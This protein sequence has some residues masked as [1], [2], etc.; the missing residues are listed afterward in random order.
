MITQ[1][2]ME[3]LQWTKRLN[4]DKVESL[5]LKHFGLQYKRY[6]ELWN[7]AG[8]DFL[9]DFPVNLDIEVVDACNLSCL[10]CTRNDDIH[11][12]MGLT[13]NTGLKF[14]L[15]SYKRICKEGR[16]YGLKAVNLGFSGECLLNNDIY[17]MINIAREYG[18]LDIRLITN[19]TLITE[20]IADTLLGTPL[21]LLSYSID[22]GNPET[23]INLKGKNYFDKLLD[24][25][26]YTYRRKTERKKDFPLI[27]VSY[28]PSPETMGD[29]EAFVNKFKE[30]VD[31]IDLQA[32][33]DI[34]KI[35]K[36]EMKTDCVMP[37]RR[38]AVFANGD[39]A[40]CCS[41][42]SKK[43]I[44]GNINKVSLKEIWDSE[45]LHSIRNGLAGG[46]PVAVCRECL[47]T[48]A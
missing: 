23:Y 6:R 45:K 48:I 1:T 47:Q 16:K 9:P 25:V 36:H 30:H 27:R 42:F 11:N 35:R 32:F 46:N 26:K 12:E 14:S 38:L 21:T 10:H 5:Y 31:F 2:A 19:G 43:L 7:R 34:K 39:V 24:I 37:F 17:N 28:Y 40:P 13:M 20:K 18:V 41:F 44:V 33:K 22:A 29:E 3:K 15:E 8:K 4:Q